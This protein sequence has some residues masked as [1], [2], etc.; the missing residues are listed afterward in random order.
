MK[1]VGDAS[2][3]IGHAVGQAMS[4]N[5]APTEKG[6]VK[7]HGKPEIYLDMD[8]VLCDFFSEYAKLAG[9]NSGNYRDIPPAKTDPTLQKMVGTDF[10]ARLPKF[11]STDSLVDMV[12]KL[13]WTTPGFKIC[14][15]P[16]R[17]D[18]D[19]SEKQKKVWLANN[20]KKS[21]NEVIITPN[22]AKWAKQPDGTPNILIDDRGSNISSWEAA[23]GIGIKY[24]ADENSLSDIVTGLNR[25]K[26]IVSGQEKHEPQ[27]LISKDRSLPVAT[28]QEKPESA[29][30]LEKESATGG[31]TGAGG[32]FGGMSGKRAKGSIVVS[33]MRK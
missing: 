23:G 20:L 7:S 15:S 8:G 16:L 28:Q 3:K 10:F 22:K 11:S 27:K 12:S 19:N 6:S 24:Q 33:G 4:K 1:P 13:G 29:A 31:G 30:D 18:F 26:K 21:P 2:Y 25:A 14:S 5:K 32:G 17:G 9:V